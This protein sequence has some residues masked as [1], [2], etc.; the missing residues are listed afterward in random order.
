MN[1]INL[2]LLVA[3]CDFLYVPLSDFSC[4]ACKHNFFKHNIVLS[5]ETFTE[6]SITNANHYESV[7]L[8]T[9]VTFLHL[10]SKVSY[11]IVN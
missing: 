4:L 5:Q 3:C 10:S 7:T 1:T 11:K 9:K 6:S 2:W 8:V